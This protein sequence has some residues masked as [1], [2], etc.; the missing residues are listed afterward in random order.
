[1]ETA[2]SGFGH[3]LAATHFQGYVAHEFV[4]KAKDPIKSLEEAFRLCDV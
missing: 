3:I 4:P 1:M 2:A